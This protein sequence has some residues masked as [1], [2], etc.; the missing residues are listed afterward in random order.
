M[1]RFVVPV[2]LVLI[3]S[4]ATGCEKSKLQRDLLENSTWETS[5]GED[6]PWEPTEYDEEWEEENAPLDGDSES[7][8]E[9]APRRTSGIIERD[10]LERVL[11]AGLGQYLQNVEMEPEF[12]R[13]SFVGFR[14]VSLF[15]GDL[16]YASLDL[17][18]GDIVTRVNG[19]AISRP[20]HASE[21][22]EQLRTAPELVVDYRRGESARRMQF[23]IVD[24]S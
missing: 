17:R 19:R 5:G 22:W 24:A 20:E 7:E 14:I 6:V 23:V 8:N 18:P 15:P 1:I 3:S 12:D 13:G 4:G 10:D 16:T 2:L 21:I 9:M 11:D